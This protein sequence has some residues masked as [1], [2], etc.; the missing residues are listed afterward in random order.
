MNQYFYIKLKD[1]GFNTKTA[2]ILTRYIRRFTPINFTDNSISHIS[3]I[4]ENYDKNNNIIVFYQ[5][6]DFS[7]F[8]HNLAAYLKSK[9]SVQFKL[10]LFTFDYWRP[11][12]KAYFEPINYKVITFA[13]N[14]E[15]L[16]I[17]L[18]QSHK[19][20]ENNF[21]FKNYWCCYNESILDI[22]LKPL[23]KL[24]IS[25]CCSYSYPERVIL[26]KKSKTN[27]NIISLG[28]TIQSDIKSGDYV[29]NKKL[30]SYFACFS[31]S[32][33]IF[34]GNP[35]YTEGINGINT[36][37]ILLKT[38]EILG[39][40]ALL[41]MPLHEE[42]YISDIGLVNM[43]NCYLIDFSKELDP[44]IDF[45]FHNID[46]FNTI[47]TKGQHHAIKY[48]NEDIMIREIKDIIES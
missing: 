23:N 38:F 8:K 10:Y 30:N 19:E 39:S 29:Y 44:Q 21:I 27:Q 33:S 7:G 15:Q 42:K 36:H 16:D 37:A 12:Y 20:W 18:K 26:H 2:P 17:F 48:L 11:S 45:I 46:L 40:G 5:H 41:V 47:R 24:F 28:G 1:P 13:K 25:G 31:S 9:K 3:N 22:N 32:V 34:W 43:D 14:V 4:L 35:R 6:K